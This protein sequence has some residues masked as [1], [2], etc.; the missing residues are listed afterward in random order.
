[1]NRKKSKHYNPLSPKQ[2]NERPSQPTD[3]SGEEKLVFQNRTISDHDPRSSKFSRYGYSVFAI[4]IFLGGVYGGAKYI[5]KSKFSKDINTPVVNQLRSARPQLPYPSPEDF[6][7]AAEFRQQGA[8]LLGCH[9]QINLIPELYGEIAKAIDRK[10]PLFA[11]VS[12]EA[13][14][15]SGLAMLKEMGLPNDSMRFLILPSE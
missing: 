5:P 13:Q 11:L 6:F 8:I 14:A 3:P 2:E 9:N 4:F 15:K 7:P 10:V 12:T 1:M